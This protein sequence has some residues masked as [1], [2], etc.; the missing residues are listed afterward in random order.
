MGVCAHV[1]AILAPLPVF[2]LPPWPLQ[3]EPG[4]HVGLAPVLV[5]DCIMLHPLSRLS[6]HQAIFHTGAGGILSNLTVRQ[7]PQTL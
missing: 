5:H 3:P 1:P 2:L 6:L 7:I 4:C